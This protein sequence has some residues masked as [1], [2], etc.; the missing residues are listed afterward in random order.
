MTRSGAGPDP[1]GARSLCSAGRYG[2]PRAAV[3]T[4]GSGDK[5]YYSANP[6]DYLSL[7]RNNP[8]HVALHC[9]TRPWRDLLDG[10]PVSF[11]AGSRG[12]RR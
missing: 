2:R 9:L 8:R 12:C 1:R 4:D 7:T 10:A 6:L 3:V 11:H 5:R